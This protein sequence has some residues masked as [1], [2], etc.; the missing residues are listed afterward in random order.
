MAA[1]RDDY[2]SVAGR[3]L[4]QRRGEKE[5]VKDVI[6]KLKIG[7]EDSVL[8]IGCGA[9]NLLIPISFFVRSIT[10]VDHPKCIERL[11]E[12][13]DGRNVNWIGKDFLG[14][15]LEERYEKVICY[16]VLHYLTDREEVYRFIAAAMRRLKP[17][18]IALFGDIPNE[19]LKRRF[20]AS[21]RGKAFLK[22]WEA[23]RAQH[24]EPAFDTQE[25]EPD[26]ETVR[27][28]DQ[29]IADI[30][31]WLRKEGYHSYIYPQPASLPFGHTR[32]DLIVEKYE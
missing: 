20:L 9:G 18:G 12:R 6:R 16:S 21:N 27:F 14:I 24:P 8:D 17:N 29:F 30:M 19:S 13:F 32:E 25:I 2:T 5:I 22:E 31:V 10:G 26:P 7:H 1:H 28:D 15:D 4:A 11:R 23:I 3:Y